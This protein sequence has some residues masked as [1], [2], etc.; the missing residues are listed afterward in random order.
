MNRERAWP[1]W[2]GWTAG[3]G[4]AV[5]ALLLLF[6]HHLVRLYEARASAFVLDLTRMGPAK[7]LG[8]AVTFR[9]Q[10]RL[11]GFSLTA[12][13]T[14][15]LLIL[16]FVA[17]GA[18]IVLSG[19]IDPIRGLRTVALVSVVVFVINQSRFLVIAGAM[20]VWG[21]RAGYERSHVFLGSVVSTLGL[22]AGVLFFVRG[23][24]ASPEAEPKKVTHAG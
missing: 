20:R 15:A 11:V 2:A 8:T 9:D 5:V 24:S 12:G 17:V 3:A 19:R 6:G 18:A 22:I 16:P 13:C 21:Y 1:D 7:S 4:L 10:G 14:S 23:M